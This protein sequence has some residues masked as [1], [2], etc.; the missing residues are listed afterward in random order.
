MNTG[1]IG[2]VVL[3]V[4]LYLTAWALA[5]VHER[6]GSHRVPQARNLTASLHHIRLVRRHRHRH[7]N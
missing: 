7:R 3:P 6:L 1:A 2:F 5:T 4:L